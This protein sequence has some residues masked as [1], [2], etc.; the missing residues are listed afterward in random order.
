MLLWRTPAAADRSALPAA[1]FDQLGADKPEE[2]Y[3][4]REPEIHD[5][6][7]KGRMGGRSESWLQL[8]EGHHFKNSCSD[9]LPASR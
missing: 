2:P 8:N 5:T 1:R 3:M 7:E 6:E 4:A 9:K